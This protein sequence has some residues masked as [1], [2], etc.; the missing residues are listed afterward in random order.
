MVNEKFDSINDALDYWER[1][2]SPI[3]INR[4]ALEES[5]DRLYHGAYMQGYNS[6]SNNYEPFINL[7]KDKA[8]MKCD[9][10]KN[11][12]SYNELVKEGD[13]E[14]NKVSIICNNCL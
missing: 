7:L 12:Y 3:N 1:I 9:K 6:Y 2:L 13:I 11:I 8:L 10:C 5:L 14:L 4:V